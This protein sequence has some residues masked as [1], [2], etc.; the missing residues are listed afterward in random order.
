MRQVILNDDQKRIINIKPQGLMIIKGVAGSGKTT[1]AVERFA[2]L[3]LDFMMFEERAVILGYTNSLTKY[4]NHLLEEKEIIGVERFEPKVIFD[5]F[6][7]FFQREKIHNRITN[8]NRKELVKPIYIDYK[9]KHKDSIIFQQDIDFVIEEFDF[10]Q[11][12][13][14]HSV[15]GDINEELKQEL[16]EYLSIT[17]SGSKVR[18]LQEQS[19]RII[20]EMYIDYLRL[21]KQRGI[22][23]YPL[24]YKKA[25]KLQLA[26]M[27]KGTYQPEFKHMIIDEAQDLSKVQMNFLVNMWDQESEGSNLIIICDVAQR[28]YKNQYR[29]KEVG[30][31]AV[32]HS[33]IL[34]KNYRNTVEI[35]QAAA[36]VLRQDVEIT[37]EEDFINP[38]FSLRHGAKPVMN[39]FNHWHMGEHKHDYSYEERNYIAKKIRYLLE[40]QNY[41]PA[42]IVVV[43]LRNDSLRLIER[44]LAE[45]G[46]DAQ[47]ISGNRNLL[48]RN[49]VSLSTMHSIKGLEFPVVFI[50][51]VNERLVGRSPL[52]REEF[53]EDNRTKLKL[54][55][56]SMTRAKELLFISSH[57]NNPSP[58]LSHEKI[59]YSLFSIAEGVKC[60]PFWDNAYY[61]DEHEKVRQWLITELVHTYGYSLEDISQEVE[62]SFGT[63]KGI[64]DI[65]VYH[66]I[67]N[68][69]LPFIVAEVK[70]RGITEGE[71]Q[72]YSY[73]SALASVMYGIRTNGN[74]IEFVKKS[75]DNGQVITKQVADL[76]EY[77]EISQDCL[78]IPTVTNSKLKVIYGSKYERNQAMYAVPVINYVSAGQCVYSQ[79][80]DFDSVY[81]PEEFAKSDRIAAAYVK[82]DS[83]LD[84]G[85][86]DGDVVLVKKQNYAENGEV[87]VFVLPYDEGYGTVC[88]KIR[89]DN[90]F[91]RLISLNEAKSYEDIIVKDF[92]Y[93]GKVVAI[94][95]AEEKLGKSW[96][97]ISPFGVS[98]GK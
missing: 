43:S 97:G 33:Y 2:R 21:L 87:G 62:V 64:A 91:A 6:K 32:G 38:E 84:L 65:I 7:E 34:R 16:E 26:S 98:V 48:C 93:I 44:T 55:Y 71:S 23:D 17:R 94:Y 79:E 92:Q 27:Q 54:L 40:E 22:V 18:N 35:A 11:S 5:V 61:K 95:K 8:E 70:S 57:S 31:E 9:E 63:R 53:I 24:Y 19:R 89:Y 68:Q 69:R 75:I 60:R 81:I 39:H 56:T 41:H 42:D 77:S 73:L 37:K 78:M 52:D 51:E 59:D 30:L 45:W 20:W 46:I 83:M 90:G 80:R 28:I 49:S 58:F 82:G 96:G 1:V 88:K 36:E 86:E 13:I 47:I 72:L 4:M 67:G 50:A 66:R 14:C 29:W 12:N 76:P 10:I 25:L 85:I 3:L 15:P 74:E